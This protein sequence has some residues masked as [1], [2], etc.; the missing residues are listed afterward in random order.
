M[1]S[2]VFVNYL[3]NRETFVTGKGILAAP[4][5]VII[6]TY[7]EELNLPYALASI[8]GWTDQII[9]VDSYSTDKTCEIAQSHRAEVCQH[10][11]EN[12]AAQRMWALEQL[13][14]KHE[15]V[16]NL[17]ADEQLTP[18]LKR[19][20]E[21]ILPTVSHDVAGFMIRRKHIFMNRWM[22][23][24]GDYIWLL[25]LVQRS[26]CR[27]VKTTM[28][29][30]HTIV[31]GK[32]LKL[33]YDLLHLNQKTLTEWIERQNKGSL[34]FTLKIRQEKGLLDPPDLKPGEHIE[35]SVRTWLNY[36]IYGRLPLS[37]RPFARFF[38]NYFLRGGFLD[39]WQG[40]VYHTINDFLYPFFVYAKY[41]E[42][43][44]S[45]HAQMLAENSKWR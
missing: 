38:L 31:D 28:V 39:G 37:L 30:E 10:R 8:K 43:H 2:A 19:E 18:E 23:H 21:V 16:F 33:R 11:Y 40:F 7:N 32:V 5:T 4:L 27:V 9:V 29:N 35:G 41:K 45:Q 1:S 14:I 44:E 24:G 25:R 42:L 12:M 6:P 34:K 15:W 3:R 26:R 22:K 36:N 17:D 13:S 20:I